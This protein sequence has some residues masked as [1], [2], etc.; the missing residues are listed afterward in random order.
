MSLAPVNVRQIAKIIEAAALLLYL[1]AS[2]T[3]AITTPIGGG[4]DENG[5]AVNAMAVADGELPLPSGL[6][7]IPEDAGGPYLSAQAHH[8]PLY[9]ALISLVYLASGGSLAA[10]T[11]GA[12]LLGVL[13][14]LGALLLTRAAARRIF[15]DRPLEIAAGMVIAAGSPTFAYITGSLNNEPLAV[16]IVAVSLYLAARAMQSIRPL[17]WL[18]LLGV[19]L[20]VGLLAKLT[21]AIAVVPLIAAAV[22]SA[23]NSENDGWRRVAMKRSLVA[24]G[25]AAAISAPWFIRNQIVFGVPTFNTSTRPIFDYP[26]DV[27]V[28]PEA[29]VRIVLFTIEE[30]MAETWRIG[31]LAKE[32][33]GYLVSIIYPSEDTL[34]PRSL[35]SVLIPLVVLVASFI[36]ILRLLK[37]QGEEGLSAAQRGFVIALMLLP[38]AGTLGV[39]HQTLMVDQQVVRWA[40]RYSPAFM[41]SLALVVSFGL[42]AL[43]PQRLRPALAITAGVVAVALLLSG[44]LEVVDFYG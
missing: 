4:P 26:I 14:G 15:P 41:P 32:H 11:Y 31:W 40:P 29:T 38:V 42:M 36:G 9:H 44:A 2:C 20:G 8:P 1:A 33:G 17:Y 39:I 22:V 7:V 25:I 6:T 34:P 12:R 3:F 43:V 35:Q 19:A 16:L 30:M 24:L 5:H 18:K 21:A 10:M 37:R 28:L 23:R 13:M 27:I